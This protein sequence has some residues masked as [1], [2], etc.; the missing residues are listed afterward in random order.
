MMWSSGIGS[1]IRNLVPRI[2]ALRPDDRF[3]L[4][5]NLAEME[6]VEGF[7][8]PNAQWIEARSPIFS[9]S[10]QLE[11]S[12]KTPADTDLFWCPH[13]NFPLFWR[14][15]LLATVHDVFHL[16]NP[17]Y[18][19]GF[20]RRFYAKFMFQRLVRKADAILCVSQFTKGELLRLTGGHAEKMK[21]IHN[22]VDSSWFDIKKAERPHPKPYLLFVGNVKP[23]KNL[24]RL[25]QA[26]GEIQGK[27][28][29]DLVIVGKKEG[30]ITGDREV[31]DQAEAFGN[32][33]RF[34]GLLEEDQLR[35]FYVFAD[36]MVFP[37]LYEGFGF[38]PLEAMA[39]G[40]PVACSN[41][42]SLPEVCGDAV[43]YFDPMDPADIARKIVQVMENT[44]AREDMVRRGAAR[45][46]GFSWATSAM[47]TN[48]AIEGVI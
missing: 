27:I 9:I 43:V 33:V 23:H 40:I 28:P 6:K 44:K 31:A 5:G 32:R 48:N 29:H 22:G 25:L 26:F 35:Q 15:K 11:I 38:P 21:V 41:A 45:A 19:A 7:R 46:K 13:Y 16:A 42:A 36:L 3:H 39:A 1:Y 34:T 24:R 4:L 12:R 17:Q 14:G 2:M 20:H 47:E 18:V 10:E 8:K 30:F 37:S